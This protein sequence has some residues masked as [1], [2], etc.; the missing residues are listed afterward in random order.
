MKY[1][2]QFVFKAKFDNIYKNNAIRGQNV[3]EYNRKNQDFTT[4]TKKFS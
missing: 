2:M 1:Q 3:R 4:I